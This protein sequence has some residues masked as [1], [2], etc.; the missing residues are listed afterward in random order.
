MNDKFQ[1]EGNKKAGIQHTHSHR[2]L[3]FVGVTLIA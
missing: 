3:I 2:L 1:H